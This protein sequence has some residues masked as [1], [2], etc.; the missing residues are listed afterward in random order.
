MD[1]HT[2]EQR[3]KNMAAVKSKNTKPEMLIRKLLHS[4]GY[5]FRLHRKDL[6]GNPDIVLPKHKTV[7]FINGCFWHQHEGCK[8][9]SVPQ[10]NTEFWQKKLSSNVERDKRNYIA[11]KDLGWNVVIIW[12]CEVKGAI[13]NTEELK[14]RLGVKLYI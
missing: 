9:A 14:E 11:L 6:P 2:P 13:D 10:T 7:I 3:C 8:H 5:R 4:L 12:E 1:N